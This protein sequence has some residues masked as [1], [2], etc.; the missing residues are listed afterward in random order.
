MCNIQGTCIY[1]WQ[2]QLQDFEGII[3]Q[4][5]ICHNNL[6][7]PSISLMLIVE[8]RSVKKGN[9]VMCYFLVKHKFLRDRSECIFSIM[10]MFRKWLVVSIVQSCFP[11]MPYKDFIKYTWML[12]FYFAFFSSEF[13]TH[14][15]CVKWH[16]SPRQCLQLKIDWCLTPTL[17][18]QLN[19]I[20][21]M[22]YIEQHLILWF[23]EKMLYFHWMPNW[24]H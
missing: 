4:L 21:T 10:F 9:Y 6:E 12:V 14:T 19:N 16:R 7:E 18:I 24:I 22:R 23:I 1:D 11:C 13:H 3:Y 2:I 20:I 5:N 8:E 17:T 15:V